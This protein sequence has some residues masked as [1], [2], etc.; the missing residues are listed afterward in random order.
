MDEGPTWSH[1][2]E[3]AAKPAATPEN[4]DWGRAEG[5]RSRRRPQKRFVYGAFPVGGPLDKIE[6]ETS[7]FKGNIRLRQKNTESNPKAE[8]KTARTPGRASKR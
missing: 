7:R 1:K 3:R 2:G 4:D 5:A 6:I 8:P